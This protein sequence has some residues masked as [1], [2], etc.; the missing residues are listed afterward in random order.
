MATKKADKQAAPAGEAPKAAA[1]P[2]KAAKGVKAL[3]KL[4]KAPNKAAKKAA[5]K[6]KAAAQEGFI[7]KA[8][9]RG[10]HVAPSKARLVVDMIRGKR[11]GK[12]LE[13]L[14]YCDKKMGPLVRKLLMSAVANARNLSAVDIDE[15][16]VKRAWV[17]EAKMLK[18]FMPRAQGRATPIRKRYSII[19]LVLDE[20]RGK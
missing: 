3:E 6:A 2:K 11:V 5:K 9:L 12:A 7:S 4:A 13:A 15:L 17:N 14:D 19:T 20:A 16:M 1:K 10:V 18:R 8:T